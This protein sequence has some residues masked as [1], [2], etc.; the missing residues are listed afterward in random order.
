MKSLSL[1]CLLKWLKKNE[2]K[3]YLFVE[4]LLAYRFNNYY[5]FY[6]KITSMQKALF[7]VFFYC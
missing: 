5:S 2:S 7:M 1:V 4:T 6:N 3:I